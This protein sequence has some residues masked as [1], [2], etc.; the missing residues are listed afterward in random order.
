[1]LIL[2]AIIT[3]VTTG[4]IG[5]LGKLKVKTSTDFIL[6][7]NK[8]GI[9]GIT[10]ML[11]GSIIGGASTV[12]TA[13]MAYSKGISA[14]WFILGISVGSILLSFIYSRRI[15]RKGAH[16]LPQI[17]GSTY[18]KKARMVSSV[19]LSLGMFIHINGQIIA[20]ISLFTAIFKINMVTTGIIVVSLL[21]VYVI[22][23]GFW[24]STLVGGI[25]T[26]LLYSTSLLCGALLIFKL[27]GMNEIITYFPKFPWFNL[28]A[29]GISEDLAGGFSTIVG[30]LSTQIYFQTIIASK[31]ASIAKKSSFLVAFLV[32][33]IGIVC[34]MI[35]MYMH[36]HYS[37]ISPNEAFP[38]FI[39]YYLHPILGGVCIATVLIS[40]IATGAGLT[41][42]IATIFVKDVYKEVINMEANDKKQL[43]MLRSLIFL[44][45]FLSFMISTSCNGFL[46]LDW[47]FLSMIFRGTPIFIPVVASIYFKDTI[48]LKNSIYPVISGPIASALWI[49]LG[50]K[51]ISSI[52]VGL[53]SSCIILFVLIK[54]NKKET[55]HPSSS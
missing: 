39:I 1:M 6:G 36:I 4:I 8:L 7:S 51:K 18:G 52:Y 3:L 50:F 28:F 53:I 45:G 33:P 9:I 49:L 26:I 46:I 10:S 24:G 12:G 38:L 22:F 40:S 43:F 5:Y 13:Q 44:I 25:K 42:G 23:G 11:M 14:I 29:N 35:G 2:S 47:G 34:T 31:N 27:N 21:I 20:C 16:T 17:I 37:H 15:N 19:L 54:M 30:V 55:I 32:F 41:L 48:K